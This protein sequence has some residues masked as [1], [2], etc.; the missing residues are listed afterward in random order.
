MGRFHPKFVEPMAPKKAAG[1]RKI[2]VGY[3]S[4]NFCHQAVSYYMANRIFHADRQKFEIQ[5][6][7]LEKR[8][9]SM[10]D[11]IKAH[12]DRFTV[13][14]DFRNLKLLRMSSRKAS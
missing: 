10:T 12:C 5:V 4:S 13:F 6:F 8:H 3:I 7:S 2:R 11:H 14:R 9:D 1:E